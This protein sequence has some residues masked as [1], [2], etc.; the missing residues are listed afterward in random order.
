MFPGRRILF[1][2][3]L[4]APDSEHDMDDL[5][6]QLARRDRLRKHLALR[7]TYA[8]RLRAMDALQEASW[9]LLRRNPE[10]YARFIRRNYKARA[11]PNPSTHVS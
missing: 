9:N 4:D 1:V 7:E 2:P 11:I 10:A 6:E 8:E 3:P 5:R